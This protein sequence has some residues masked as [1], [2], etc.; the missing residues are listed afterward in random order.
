MNLYFLVEGETERIIYPRWLKQ[1]LPTLTKIR[2]ASDVREN[3]YYLISG[4]GYPGLLDNHLPNAVEEINE[5]G[6]YDYFIISL[7]ADELTVAERINEVQS[8]ILKENIKLVNCQLEIIVQ[9]RCM[10]TWFMGNRK[11]FP[12]NPTKDFEHFFRFY[13]VSENDPEQ[14]EKPRDFN[15][16]IGKFHKQY[17][18]MM[19]AE[20]NIRYSETIPN[21]V[22]ELEY[23]QQLQKRVEEFPDHL[24]TLYSFIVLLQNI[25]KR[26]S[27]Y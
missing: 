9:N 27:T 6:R 7:D 4:G 18:K 16:A 21:A 14:M 15:G 10:E 1:L 12:R 17:L 3:N 5:M 25:G 20:K 13:N 11:V 22:G 24:K 19:L 26:L 2:V 23:L 8:K